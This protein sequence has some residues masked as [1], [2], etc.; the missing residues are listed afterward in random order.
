MNEEARE[1]LREDILPVVLGHGIEAHRFAA[2]LLSRYGVACVLCGERK[3]LLDWLDLSTGF[4]R[5]SYNR[6]LR[7]AAEQLVDFAEENRD[8]FLL[9]IEMK[10]SD[11]NW[12]EEQTELIETRFVCVEPNELEGDWLNTL[13]IG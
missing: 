3:N 8:R 11:R 1:L 4:F 13:K 9:L 6:D 2:R 5:I 12:S 7:L 10:E